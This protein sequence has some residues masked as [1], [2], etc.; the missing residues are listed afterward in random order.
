MVSNSLLRPDSGF[1]PTKL[2]VYSDQKQDSARL[3]VFLP[4]NTG[5]EDE[6]GHD[7]ETPHEHE[8]T[9]EPLDEVGQDRP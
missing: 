7:F 5:E 8:E 1:A 3:L 4:E 6:D 9:E 2:R